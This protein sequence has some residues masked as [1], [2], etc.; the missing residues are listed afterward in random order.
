MFKA[1]NSLLDANKKQIRN[2][3]EKI[4]NEYLNGLR[5]S[6][7]NALNKLNPKN[8]EN[9]ALHARGLANL[10]YMYV[11]RTPLDVLSANTEKFAKYRHAYMLFVE[12]EVNSKKYVLARMHLDEIRKKGWECKM[13]RDLERRIKMECFKDEYKEKTDYSQLFR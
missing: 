1:V 7:E 13:V 10:A 3:K 8:E 9:K 5:K 2:E 6:D 11:R 12:K 4:C